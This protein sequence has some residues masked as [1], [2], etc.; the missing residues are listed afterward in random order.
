MTQEEYC[1]EAG[2]LI[3]LYIHNE[4][5]DG[6]KDR[7]DS[8][9]SVCGECRRLLD[10][11]TAA[12]EAVKRFGDET[13]DIVSAVMKYIIENKITIDKP[14]RRFGFAPSLIPAAVVVIAVLVFS[15]TNIMR[16]MDGNFGSANSG[17]AAYGA[18]DSGQA[19]M[20]DGSALNIAVGEADDAA[21]D[22]SYATPAGEISASGGSDEG[23]AFSETREFSSAPEAADDLY[24][25]V[26]SDVNIQDMT[27]EYDADVFNGVKG[28]LKAV[29]TDEEE[30]INTLIVLSGEDEELLE[31]LLQDIEYEKINGIIKADISALN[32]FLKNSNDNNY[33]D[34]KIYQ[35][36]E[37]SNVL[38]ITFGE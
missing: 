1:C 15:R 17:G 22:D 19:D 25:Y 7:F 16:I 20:K 13:P 21:Y 27:D 31:E 8:H 12:V 36:N 9:I 5:D 38:A 18:Y 23:G 29:G 4:L 34:Y 26:E 14:K 6:Q 24:A 10:G 35:E 37:Q 30:D 32:R 2:E 33:E 3:D 11:E 28:R